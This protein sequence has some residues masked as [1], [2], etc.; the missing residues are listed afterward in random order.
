MRKTLFNQIMKLLCINYSSAYVNH[1]YEFTSLFSLPHNSSFLPLFSLYHTSFILP[2]SHP[3]SIPLPLL[4]PLPVSQETIYKSLLDFFHS[5]PSKHKI[6][7][8]LNNRNYSINICQNTQRTTN[9]AFYPR[10]FHFSFR[11]VFQSLSCSL[12][13]TSST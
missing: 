6:I 4:T 9:I 11:F 3:T 7:I 10:F 8:N 2:T 1:S 5:S 12:K 13:L